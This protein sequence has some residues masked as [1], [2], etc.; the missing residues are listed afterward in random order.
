MKDVVK[1]NYK[2]KIL[3]VC[4]RLFLS[5]GISETGVAD[6][7]KEVGISKGTLYYHYASKESIIF[8]V[9]ERYF[10][11]T[12]DALENLLLVFKGGIS[13]EDGIK[14]VLCVLKAK[15]TSEKMHYI[16]MAYGI[17]KDE[18]L[19]LKFKE[20]YNN[21]INMIKS[22]LDMFLIDNK[23]NEIYSHLI[24]AL[25]DGLALNNIL[26]VIGILDDLGTMVEF[27]KTIVI[28]DKF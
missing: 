13:V 21:W 20:R 12:Q 15:K 11:K 9:A 2:E 10:A 25:F 22:A 3:D 16:L 24:M 17:M 7:A 23:N 4:E 5:N 1:N 18:E 14:T 6:I 27:L 19:K 28:I 8:A 26:G